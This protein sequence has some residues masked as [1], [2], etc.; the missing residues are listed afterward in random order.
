VGRGAAGV[1]EGGAEVAKDGDGLAVEARAE[2]L[3]EKEGRSELGGAGKMPGS[4][5]MLVKRRGHDA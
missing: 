1:A 2:V 4:A 3:R 5:E